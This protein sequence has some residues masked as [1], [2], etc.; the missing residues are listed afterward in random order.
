ML[1]MVAGY[2]LYRMTQRAA[3][4]ADETSTY[5]AVLPTASPVLV[6]VAQEVAIEMADDASDEEETAQ[7]EGA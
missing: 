6:E 2:A 4:N 5:A 7:H 1:G 3:P